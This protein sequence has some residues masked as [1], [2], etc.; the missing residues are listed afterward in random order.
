MEWFVD[1]FRQYPELA[2]FLT[3]ALGFF[4]GKFKYGTFSLGNVTSVLLVG[5]IVGQ[6]KIVIAPEVKQIF[7]LIFLFAVGYSVGPQF[8]NSLKKSGIPQL[9]FGTLMSATALA[10][11]WL[12]AKMMG[13]SAGQAA[14]LFAGAQ[15]ISA[16][17]GVG[18]ETINSLG[19]DAATK[20]TMINAIPVCY[21]VTYL[22]GTIG[23]AFLLAQVGPLFWGGMKKA[24]EQCR[25][26]ESKMG[27]D[28]QDQPSMISSYSNVVFRGYNLGASLTPFLNNVGFKSNKSQ[29]R[30]SRSVG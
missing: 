24:R 11:T 16:V 19:L 3:I 25:D 9:I 1:T 2:I 6:M 13:Y 22:F 14:G 27:V 23:S 10:T 8:F 29:T 18:G 30:N 26:L 15:T 5:V 7:F 28:S 21:A 20:Q 17:I 4:I 12:L